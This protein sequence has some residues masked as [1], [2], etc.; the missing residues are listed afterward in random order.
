MVAED[1]AEEVLD[2]PVG[3]TSQEEK[4]T[5][6]TTEETDQPE[7]SE[8]ESPE[9]DKEIQSR[10]AQI[11][12]WRDKAQKFEKEAKKNAPKVESKE[13]EATETDDFRPRI[14]FLLTNRDLEEK[15]YT[16]IAAV[17]MRDS[18]EISLESL[19]TA[20]ETEKDYLSFLKEKADNKRKSPS[21]TSSGGVPSSV[22]T[23]AEIGEMSPEE[24]RALDEKA[25]NEESRGI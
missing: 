16:H 19:Q 9:L 20:K 2:P 4:E 21:S 22:K 12:H 8:E 1:A 11:K 7:E 3:D 15:E 14:E 24:H 6:E 23:F 25:M 10:D 17:A 13:S 5:Q 18:G